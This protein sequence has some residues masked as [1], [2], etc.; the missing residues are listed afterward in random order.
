[1]TQALDNIRRFA[2]YLQV[3]GCSIFEQ[4]TPAQIA[5]YQAR[6]LTVD[7]SSA[8]QACEAAMVAAGGG[9]V[10]FPPGAGRIESTLTKRA[11]GVTWLGLG[12]GGEHDQTGDDDFVA[13]LYWYGSS[14]GTMIDF[15]PTPG[16]GARRLTGGGIVGLGLFGRGSAAI[17]VS[18]K[19][20]QD[21]EIRVY[22]EN[23]TSTVAYVGV[24]ATLGEARDSQQNRIRVLAKQVGASSGSIITLDGDSGANAS[25]NKIH[26]RGLYKFG[27]AVDLINCD[28]NE[29]YQW[30][31]RF[32]GGT[33]K[34]L[35]SRGGATAQEA[36]RANTWTQLMAGDGGVHIEGTDSG[37]ASASVRNVCLSWDNDNMSYEPTI[38]VG[39]SFTKMDLDGALTWTDLKFER[40]T[41]LDSV[42]S[43]GGKRLLRKT[44]SASADSYWQIT[45]GTGSVA[46]TALSDP[47]SNVGVGLST[48]GTGLGALYGNNY[49]VA[50]IKWNST[51]VGFN[52]NAPVAQS[53]GW[54]TPT[55][56]AVVANFN[57][58]TA[59]L[60]QCTQAVA[61][62]LTYLKSRGDIGT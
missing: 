37:W 39:A 48:K 58:S 8:V 19:S 44:F 59:T 2:S 51:G 23:F 21:A 56:G 18:A 5:D 33:G 9:F 55:N 42:W 26:V 31:Y 45:H 61:Q 60:G 20:V 14:G 7:I 54:G 12:A 34:G 25:H 28:N 41:T 6:T 4:M 50:P 1:M 35:R 32:G 62:I 13:A 16:A 22:G 38:G 10:I 27:D 3:P 17:G 53:T 47:A 46:M 11:S 30:T 49:A 29:I 43:A 52:G 40:L 24:V 36:A 57:G 15:S